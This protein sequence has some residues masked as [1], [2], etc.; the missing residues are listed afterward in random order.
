MSTAPQLPLPPGPASAPPGPLARLVKRV[1]ALGPV[2]WLVPIVEIYTSAGGGLLAAGLAF[3]S[4]FAILPAILLVIGVV[5]VVLGDTDRLEALTASLSSAFPPMAD[6]FTVALSSF[7]SGATTYSLIGLVF[8][9]WGASRFY[10]SLDEAL[11]RIFRS[12]VRRGILVRN[13]LGILWV[14][15]LTVLIVGLILLSRLVGGDAEVAALARVASTLGAAGISL[16]VFGV[17]LAL[18]YRLVPTNAPDWRHVRRPAVVVGLF[19]TVFTGAFA[20]LAPSLIGSLKVYG[21]FVAVFAA[22]LWLSV[23]SQALLIGAAWTH[24]RVRQA[25]MASAAR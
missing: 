6:F 3:S 22:M 23:L 16:V 7:A 17:G 12:T 11:A 4:L 9:A 15:V 21:A 24:H 14:V 25:G 10:Q 8:L 20:L 18:V 13:I 19:L 2:A 1:L 5:G